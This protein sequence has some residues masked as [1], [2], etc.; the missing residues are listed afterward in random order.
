MPAI[1]G[2]KLGMT[3]VFDDAGNVVPV[4]IVETGP[5]VVVGLRTAER[6]GYAAVQLG[7]GTRKD[8][9]LTKAYK[10]TFAKRGLQPVRVV[11]EARAAADDRVEIGQALGADVFSRGDRVDVVGVSKG[12]G[13]AGA[14]KRHNFGGQRDSHGNSLMHRAPGSIGS[15]NVARVFKGQRMPGRLGGART[16][17]RG[18]RVVQVDTERNVLLLRGAVPGPRGSVVLVRRAGG[19]RACAR[20]RCTTARASA[21]ARSS[22]RRASLISGRTRPS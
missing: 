20:R 13:F 7:F 2:K 8:A 14:M 6:D 11:R 12:K 3:Q 18:L 15:S 19:G 21:S 4:T 17:V 16:T 22:S 9:R 5:C 10:G 1:L